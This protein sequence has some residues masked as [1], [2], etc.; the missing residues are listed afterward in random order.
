[1]DNSFD[2]ESIR[3]WRV[4]KTVH[5]LVHDRGYVVSQAELDLSLADFCSTFGGGNS[6]S[7]RSVLNFIVQGK[8]D[9]SEQL[10][11]FFPED[12]SVGVKPIRGYLEKMNE[13]NVHNAIIIY[14]QN[15]T[16]SASKVLTSMAPKYILEQF[17]ESELIV[18]IT[19]HV[20]VPQHIVLT[21]SEKKALLEKY[22]LKD[23]QLPRILVSDPIARYYG[24]KRGQVVKILRASETAGRYVTFRLAV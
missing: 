24:L 12:I 3:L 16:P 17:S 21:P 5:Q 9:P 6:I 10:F 11:V 22:R 8:E 7:D 13:Q 23:N 2:Q 19:E 4:H 14:R 15:M 18:N 1:M 20:L